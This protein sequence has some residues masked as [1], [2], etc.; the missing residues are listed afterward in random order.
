MCLLVE[1]Y[2]WGTLVVGR[3]AGGGKAGRTGLLGWL[4]SRRRR[5]GLRG[6]RGA[7]APLFVG[8]VSVEG[9]SKKRGVGVVLTAL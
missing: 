9:R 1:G 6:A 8:V 4:S 7:V 5:V 2:S 3:V